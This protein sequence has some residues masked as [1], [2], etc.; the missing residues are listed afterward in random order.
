MPKRRNYD[1]EYKNYQGSEE[2]KHNRALRNKAR[3]ELMEEGKVHKGDGLDVD[4]KKPL[5]KGGSD[6][7]SNLRVKTDMLIVLLRGLKKPVINNVY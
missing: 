4:H 6:D 2:Q 7:R 5:I 3:R 1:L